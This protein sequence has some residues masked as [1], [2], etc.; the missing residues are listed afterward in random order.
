MNTGTVSAPTAIPIENLLFIQSNSVIGYN[1]PPGTEKWLYEVIRAIKQPS[2][3]DIVAQIRKDY[4]EN[5]NKLIC[6]VREESTF[7]SNLSGDKGLAYGCFQIHIDKHEISY[8]CAMDFYCS[9]DWTISQIRAGKGDLWSPIK[10][11]TCK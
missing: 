8:E 4:P 10:K 11:G 7:C 3:Q 2:K 5:P 1:L 9:L 6:L